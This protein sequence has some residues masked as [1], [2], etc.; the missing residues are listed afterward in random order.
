[1]HESAGK[2]AFASTMAKVNEGA[3]WD[4][5]SVVPAVRVLVLPRV[6]DPLE[7]LEEGLEFDLSIRQLNFFESTLVSFAPAFRLAHDIHKNQKR[8][9]DVKDGD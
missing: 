5:E 8:V 4:V 6:L 1:M 7:D 2:D 9:S 3:A